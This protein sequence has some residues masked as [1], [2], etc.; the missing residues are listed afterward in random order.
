MNAYLRG[1]NYCLAEGVRTNE[2]LVRMNPS[3]DAQKIYEKT[4]IRR[5][6]VAGPEE[7]ASDLAF[8]AAERLLNELAFDRTQVD[9]LIFCTQSPDYF[10]PTSACLLQHR[11]GLPTACGAFDVNLGCSG[12]TY[13]LWLARSLL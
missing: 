8:R 10:L 6:P 13:G 2:D 4:G 3:W 11:L 1:V 12:F 7:T 5:R 9:A